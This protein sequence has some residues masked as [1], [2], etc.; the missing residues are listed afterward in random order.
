MILI[1]R[2]D[3]HD[4]T[5]TASVIDCALH[6]APARAT[7]S[8]TEGEVDDPRWSCIRRDAWDGAAR[9][10]PNG[11]CNVAGVAKALTERANRLEL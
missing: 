6:V 11:V 7:P 1:P 2:C 5:A 10:P 8:T 9:S 4:G 3:H